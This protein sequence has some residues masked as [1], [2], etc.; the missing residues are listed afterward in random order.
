M[1]PSLL[2]CDQGLAAQK[3]QGQGGAGPHQV[4]T[5]TPSTTTHSLPGAH[6]A[7]GLT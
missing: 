3:R 6:L 7:L 2:A 5:V 1:P 4:A